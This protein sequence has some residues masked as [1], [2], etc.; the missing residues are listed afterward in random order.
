MGVGLPFVGVVLAWAGW[1]GSPGAS[2]DALVARSGGARLVAVGPALV[3]G[4]WTDFVNWLR[5]AARPGQI[6]I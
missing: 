4:V 2:A 1:P 5:A 3:T 6:G